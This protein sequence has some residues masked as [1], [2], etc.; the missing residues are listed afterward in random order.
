MAFGKIGGN[1]VSRGISRNGA[2]RREVK[3]GRSTPERFDG[4]QLRF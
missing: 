4:V 2:T 1:V 3:G